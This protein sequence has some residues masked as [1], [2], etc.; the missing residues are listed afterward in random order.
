MEDNR[1][2]TTNMSLNNSFG[3]NSSSKNPEM[4]LQRIH[5]DV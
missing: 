4:Q 3:I 5:K 1:N 2:M